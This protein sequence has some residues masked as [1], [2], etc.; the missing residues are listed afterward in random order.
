MQRQVFR[1]RFHDNVALD[2]I[3]AEIVLALL[4]VESLHGPARTRL[5]ATHFLD[6]D[7]RTLIVDATTDV[8]EDFNRL[9]VGG[10]LRAYG[11]DGFQVTRLLN[12]PKQERDP[13]QA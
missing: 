9:L 2:D 1:Y 12:P 8:G 7:Q 4:N 6:S 13:C 11:P 5:E 3:E 10:L